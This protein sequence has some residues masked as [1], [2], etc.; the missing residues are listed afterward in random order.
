MNSPIRGETF[1]ALKITGATS[2]ITSG[3]QDKL[4]LGNLDAKTDWGH[5]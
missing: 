5:F 2:K 1:M 3:S 4:Y